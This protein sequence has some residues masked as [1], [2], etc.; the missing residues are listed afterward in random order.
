M[1]FTIIQKRIISFNIINRHR[2]IHTSRCV[3]GNDVDTIEDTPLN[4]GLQQLYDRH[5]SAILYSSFLERNKL[6]LGYVKTKV[7]MQLLKKR[8]QKL[9]EDNANV[10]PFSVALKYWDESKTDF[11]EKIITKS[12]DDDSQWK[13]DLMQEISYSKQKAELVEE[14]QRSQFAVADRD[15][16]KPFV[17]DW[18]NDYDIFDDTES[19]THSQF[20]TPDPSVPVSK[21]PCYG[22][23]ALLQCAE[24]SLPGY[25]PS[26]LFKGKEH[27]VLKVTLQHK[28]KINF[29]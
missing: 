15:E 27:S 13:A 20:G 16:Q 8:E 29:S 21:I 5:K 17:N 12:N 7:L 26:E 22:C 19:S 3:H 25:L 6:N 18:M 23:G 11:D 10:R 4:T 24:P 14:F 28:I 2:L 1:R 9:A